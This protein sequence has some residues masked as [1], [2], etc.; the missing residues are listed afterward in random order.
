MQSLPRRLLS[1]ANRGILQDL[2]ADLTENFG[3]IHL[4][5]HDYCY[6]F[7]HQTREPVWG[8]SL[9]G[10]RMPATLRKLARLGPL[11][12]SRGSFIPGYRDRLEFGY[13]SFYFVGTNLEALVDTA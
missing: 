1:R 9:S 11:M 10:F 8:A 3:D 5:D 12:S 6:S 4:K 2:R 7:E 13:Y